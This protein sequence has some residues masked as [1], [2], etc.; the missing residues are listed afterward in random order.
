MK[1]GFAT[2]LSSSNEMTRLPGSVKQALPVGWTG[3]RLAEAIGTKHPALVP[4]FGNDI[5]VDLM[6]TES[7]ILVAVLLRLARMGIAALPM[8]DGIMVPRSMIDRGMAAMGDASL[9]IAGIPLPV[10]IK[11]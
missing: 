9:E 4:L 1:A 6:F 2:M 3:R 7:C 8:H 11:A 5:A 10:V